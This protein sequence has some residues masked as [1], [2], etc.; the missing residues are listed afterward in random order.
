[1]KISKKVSAM[2]MILGSMLV[3]NVQG[4]NWE[5]AQSAGGKEL[6]YA[7]GIVNDS[8][9]NAYVAGSF[10]GTATFGDKQLT[11]AGFFD[12]YIAKYSPAGK[13]LWVFQAGG[14][15]G[16]EAYGLT[17]D[18]NNSLYVTGYFSGK[19][20]FGDKQL[21]SLG[22]RDFFIAKLNPDGKLLW[23]QPGGGSEDEFGKAIT[24]DNKGNIFVTGIFHTTSTFSKKIIS[25]KG[26]E[27]VFLANYST[28]GNLKWIKSIG[29]GGRDEATAIEADA[30]GNSYLTGWFTGLVDFGKTKLTA[31]GDD[32]IFIAKYNSNGEEVWAN[33]AGGFKG[34][35]RSYGITVDPQGNSYITGSFN[36]SAKFSSVSLKSVGADD[37]FLAKYNSSGVMQW[38]KQSGGK[39]GEI[40]R[41]VDLDAA[42]N[43]Y[44]CGDF[45]ASFIPS[46]TQSI[47]DWDLF[48]VKFDTKGNVI[49]SNQA[50]GQGY[51][52]PT[53]MSIDKNAG[54]YVTG[55][56]EKTCN[57]GKQSLT[58]I[59]NSDIFIAKAREFEPAH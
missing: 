17:I 3:L 58:N 49:G 16:D 15:E 38:V 57:F 22:N 4:Q 12:I 47:G 28:D 30:N 5:W 19:A 43:I 2:S 37:F 34:A 29:G 23:V 27:D 51:D 18:S 42:G 8:D 48:I 50:G 41:A 14:S 46:S 25:S 40:G 7:N 24:T 11:S 9:G 53:A 6:D 10:N 55:V 13:V 52:R 32:D 56:F 31:S 39:N 21:T 45:N 1:M 44:V 35:D 33:Q 59:G 20:T 26:K 36:G 54:V